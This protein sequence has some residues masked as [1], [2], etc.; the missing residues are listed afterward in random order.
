MYDSNYVRGQ[1]CTFLGAC[2]P[3]EEAPCSSAAGDTG[4]SGG[5]DWKKSTQICHKYAILPIIQCAFWVNG[6]GEG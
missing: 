3:K 4:L 2:K 1:M 5:G 6:A